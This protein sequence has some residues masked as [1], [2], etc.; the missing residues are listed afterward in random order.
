MQITP[1][2]IGDIICLNNRSG[3]LQ[4]EF[5]DD[6]LVQFCHE[7]G[8]RFASFSHEIDGSVV[9]EPE[10]IQQ[11]QANASLGTVL[12][13][14]E[15]SAI[16]SLINGTSTHEQRRDANAVLL[17]VK[18]LQQHMSDRLNPHHQREASKSHRSLDAIISKA[19]VDAQAQQL[20]LN[21]SI[22]FG[23]ER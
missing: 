23:F 16:R 6:E 10:R 20:S 19:S 8:S 13:N 12:H 4:I 21:P 11:F 18:E 9:Q 14:A 22:P 2:N 3:Y 17:S 15:F 7:N 1:D 5:V